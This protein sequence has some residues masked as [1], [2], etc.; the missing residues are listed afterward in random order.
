MGLS[1]DP[2]AA[3]PKPKVIGNYAIIAALGHGGMGE[4]FQARD[5]RLDRSVALKF[6]R[7]AS[8]SDRTA[9]D[10]F[11]LEA[12]AASA[13]NHPNIVTIYEIGDADGVPFIAMELIRGRTIRSVA[14]ES[15]PLEQLAEIGAQ[16]A[17]ALAVAH[18]AGIVH[19]D[20]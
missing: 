9:V 3:A 6:L 15:L 5:I 18:K 16:V 10:R 17:E 11:F 13:L 12:R 4:V 8:A 14:S 1:H 19:R 2:A 20:I 7:T